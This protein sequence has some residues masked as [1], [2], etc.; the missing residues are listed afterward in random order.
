M[1]T[2]NHPPQPF[3][4][5]DALRL[6]GAGFGALALQ[7]LYGWLLAGG[8]AGT[9]GTQLLTGEQ[10]AQLRSDPDWRVRYEAASRIEPELLAELVEDSDDLV[11]E[12]AFSRSSLKDDSRK[13]KSL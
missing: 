11:R 4:R 6:A 9:I 13:E 2:D 10:L 1:L 5:R 7:G 3:T 12:M 8:D